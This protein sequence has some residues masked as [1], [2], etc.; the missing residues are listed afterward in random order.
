MSQYTFRQIL[1]SRFDNFMAKGG[2]SIFI[3][4]AVVFL[5]LLGLIS[6]IRGAMLMT[7]PAGEAQ[8]YLEREDPSLLNNIYIVFLQM[9]DPGNMNQDVKSTALFKVSAI[10]AGLTG[11]IMLS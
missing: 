8:A 3:S 5:S 10:A 11:V 9:T 1:R 6:L 2:R 7:I 4:L